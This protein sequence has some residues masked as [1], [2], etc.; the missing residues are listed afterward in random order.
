MKKIL[1]ALAAIAV[2]GIA[3]W[4]LY[5]L[6]TSIQY[7]ATNTPTQVLNSTNENFAHG[8]TLKIA[9]DYQGAEAAYT[10]ALRTVTDSTQEEQI[11]LYIGALKYIQQKDPIGAIRIF[12]EIA[13]NNKYS[14]GAR[15]TAVQ[16]LS[17][18]NQQNADAAVTKE[19]F[20]TKPYTEML[21]QADARLSERYLAEYASSFYPLGLTEGYIASWY[22]RAILSA[23]SSTAINTYKSQVQAK[24]KSIDANVALLRTFPPT[25]SPVPYV[26]MQKANVVAEMALAKLSTPQEAEDLYNQAMHATKEYNSAPGWDG[27]LRLDY[28]IYLSRMYGSTRTQDIRTVLAPL[29]TPDYTKARIAIFL[30]NIRSGTFDSQKT[31][32]VAALGKIDPNFKFLLI[33][34]GWQESDFR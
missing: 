10:L 25:H 14:A 12:K 21:V 27:F 3:A 6:Q 13:A 31:R 18:I 7:S 2:V 5:S 11:K 16:W 4:A 28:A 33:D 15:A 34:L 30:K 1:Y 26:L 17:T 24:L 20:S 8:H 32:Y 19:I 23:T 22:T 9:G 29:S